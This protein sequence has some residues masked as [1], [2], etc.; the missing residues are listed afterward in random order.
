VPVSAF[1]VLILNPL[2]S[3]KLHHYTVVLLALI[4]T[5]TLGFTDSSEQRYTR[6]GNLEKPSYLNQLEYEVVLE[7]N[8]LR[9][10][11]KEYAEKYLEPMLD[12][13][14]GKLLKYPNEIPVRTN[15]GIKAVKECIRVLKKTK[16]IGPFTPKEGMSYAAADHVKYQSKKGLTG[17]KGKGGS[18]PFKRLNK[19]G[20]WL[21]TAGENID[22]GNDKADRIVISLMVDDGVPDRGHRKNI[23]NGDFKVIGV[24]VGTH[25]KYR[26]MCVMTLAGDYADN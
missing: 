25:K 12:L 10:N 1:T 22:Y 3:M 20:Q 15:E 24:A 13:Y 21:I 2:I 23:L 18:T 16:P 9:A 6:Q 7:L 26:H 14:D 19:H 17:H 4:L 8:K 11:P 5:V